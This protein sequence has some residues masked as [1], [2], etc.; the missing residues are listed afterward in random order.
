MEA[1]RGST[2]D[3]DRKNL[4]LPPATVASREGDFS[5]AA[6]DPTVSPQ[7]CNQRCEPRYPRRTEHN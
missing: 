1:A 3:R 5:V 2:F 4:T 6:P 7:V